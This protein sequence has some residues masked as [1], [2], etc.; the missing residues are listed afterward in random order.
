MSS[1]IPYPRN[2]RG[3]GAI[4]LGDLDPDGRPVDPMI[5]RLAYEKQSELARYRA[6]EMNDEAE[7]A[8]LIELA[9]YKTS[10]AATERT[11][12]DPAG[13]LFRTYSHLVDQVL[14]RVVRAFGVEENILAGFAS[15]G[16]DLEE[17]LIQK[18]TRQQFIQSMD[19]KGRELWEQYLLGYGI[20]ELALAEGQTPEYLG[21]RL[22]RAV[23]RVLRRLTSDAQ[24]QL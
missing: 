17:E 20:P 21:K 24:S 10:R 13:Y 23:Q 6:H 2:K 18:L 12:S 22:R 1:A 4:W 9:A 19:P 8:S 11:L 14:R 5:K 3:P 7:V 16:S 15:V